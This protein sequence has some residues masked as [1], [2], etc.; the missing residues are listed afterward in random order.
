MKRGPAAIK[1]ITKGVIK[2]LSNE[3]Q[4]K[5]RK[6]K[7]VLEKVVGRRH[8][9]HIQPVSF[10]RK[11]L[12]VNVDSSS[13]LYVLALKKEEIAKKLKKQLKDDFQ[14]IRFRIG[15]IEE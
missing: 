2:K 9:I 1:D 10:K 5:E 4:R 7:R 11:K 12:V 6:I 14:E 3:R 8:S 13:L 15:E